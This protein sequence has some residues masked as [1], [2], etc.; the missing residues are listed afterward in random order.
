MKKLKQLLKVS[1]SSSSSSSSSPLLYKGFD[2]KNSKEWFEAKGIDYEK[3]KE[4]YDQLCK[5]EFEKYLKEKDSKTYTLEELQQISK[6]ISLLLQRGSEIAIR[7][8]DNRL[9]ALK[10]EPSLDKEDTG[11]Q[12]KNDPV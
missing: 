5:N 9:Q 3:A 11:K 12:Y 2:F 7:L 8:E 6:Q 4:D 10:G 1:S